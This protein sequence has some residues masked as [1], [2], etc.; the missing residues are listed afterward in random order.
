[1]KKKILSVTVI[2]FLLMSMMVSIAGFDPGQV[3]DISQYMPAGITVSPSSFSVLELSSGISSPIT[4]TKTGDGSI[5]FGAGIQFV[6]MNAI[7]NFQTGLEMGQSPSDLSALN[8]GVNTD[9]LTMLSGRSATIKV[10]NASNRFDVSLLSNENWQDHIDI[11]VVNNAGQTV[12][13]SNI[14]QYIDFSAVSYD[15][16]TDQLTVPVNHFTT[17]VLKAKSNQKPNDAEFQ[18]LDGSGT[19]T[20]LSNK[21]WGIT[22]SEEILLE[23]LSE[24]ISIYKIDG[25]NATKINL[26]FEKDDSNSAKVLINHQNL[27]EAGNYTLYIDNGIKSLDGSKNLK[28]K[29]RY[30]FIVE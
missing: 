8:F 16:G 28:Y 12:G 15:S 2:L 30:S 13:V 25:E 21:V 18:A 24:N 9:L 26:S 4:F 5:T 20:V 27:F 14:S 7:S 3:I 1:M 11:S 6:D 22:F 23:G 19:Q 29:Y 17:Y 10:F